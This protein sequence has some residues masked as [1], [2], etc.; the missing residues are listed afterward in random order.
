MEKESWGRNRG[1]GIME[2]ESWRRNRGGGIVQWPMGA[3]GGVWEASGR[4]RGICMGGWGG[5][6]RSGREM[7]NFVLCF[8]DESGVTAYSAAEGRA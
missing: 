6:G 2:E 8:T 7:N 5:H 4:R 1:A 3:L